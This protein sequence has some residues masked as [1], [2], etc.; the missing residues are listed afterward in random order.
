MSLNV[1]FTA[2][3]SGVD[4]AGGIVIE[5]PRRVAGTRSTTVIRKVVKVCL[6]PV[7]EYIHEWC[8]VKK[9]H[10]SLVD[11]SF[12]CFLFDFINE[13]DFRVISV[14]FQ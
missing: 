11:C 8:E 14:S 2:T 7:S 4:F 13:V 6:T 10:S 12:V 5:G 3:D 9:T 1:F